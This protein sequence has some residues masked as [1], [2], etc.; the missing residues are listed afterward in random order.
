M[1]DIHYFYANKKG[2]IERQSMDYVTAW[3]KGFEEGSALQLRMLNSHTG[4]TFKNL[5]EVI[6][7]IR[8]TEM[9][10][11]WEEEHAEH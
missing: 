2:G 3:Q 10:K 8:E 1:V 6:I 11:K 4:M 5:T 9:M 7:Y